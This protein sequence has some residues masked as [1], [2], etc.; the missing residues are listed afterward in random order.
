MSPGRQVIELGR[1]LGKNYR[2]EEYYSERTGNSNR[3]R[4]TPSDSTLFFW[5][6]LLNLFPYFQQ[7]VLHS[8]FFFFFKISDREE[9][10]SWLVLRLIHLNWRASFVV[11]TNQVNL[12]LTTLTLL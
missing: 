4:S 6:A 10:H 11:N 1:I 7:R 3:S 8:F 5:F 12:Q 2:A 9:L